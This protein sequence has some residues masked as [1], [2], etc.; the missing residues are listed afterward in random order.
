VISSESFLPL[1]VQ[2]GSRQSGSGGAC[3]QGAA[4]ATQ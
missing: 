2:L 1:G 4:R 3:D